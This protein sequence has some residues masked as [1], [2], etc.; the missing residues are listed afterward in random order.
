MKL[1]DQAMTMH[2]TVSNQ[3]TDLGTLKVRMDAVEKEVIRL[4]NSLNEN[5]AVLDIKIELNIKK[6]NHAFKNLQSNYQNEIAE[7]RAEVLEKKIDSNSHG[8]NQKRFK[9]SAEEKSK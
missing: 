8:I 2:N 5:Y 3:S 4:N 6:M 9:N 1:Y 7:L